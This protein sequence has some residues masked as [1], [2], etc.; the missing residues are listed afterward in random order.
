MGPALGLLI[1]GSYGLP[2]GPESMNVTSR[3]KPKMLGIGRELRLSWS[4]EVRTLPYSRRESWGVGNRK[5]KSGRW[6]HVL[7]ALTRNPNTAGEEQDMWLWWGFISVPRHLASVSI[8]LKSQIWHF[9]RKNGTYI[10]FIYSKTPEISPCQMSL[11]L[12]QIEFIILSKWIKIE[13]HL[14]NVTFLDVTLYTKRS[15]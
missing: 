14:L 11:L 10:F 9:F 3:G 8:F 2:S 4:Q 12:L 13:C 7:P 15:F 1:T 5:S 6:W